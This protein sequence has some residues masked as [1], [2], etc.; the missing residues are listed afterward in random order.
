ME[1]PPAPPEAAIIR[2]AREAANIRIA[3][4]AARAGVSVARWSQIEAGS[5]LRHG[6]ASPVTGRAG[7]IAR[8]AHVAGVSPERL[9][10]AGGRPDAAEI[11]REIIRQQDAAGG[12][13]VTVAPAR[14]AASDD[15][16]LQKWRQQV[17]REA[18]GAAGVLARLGPGELPEPDDIPGAAEVLLGL[19][20]ALIFDAEHE[21]SAWDSGALPLEKKINV[22]ALT[23]RFAARA[24][25]E[26]GRRTGLGH[27]AATGAVPA[28]F[29]VAGKVLRASS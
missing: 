18:Y 8:M 3:D 24:D 2:L 11:L 26:Q 13:A 23:R 19:P 17:L 7:T 29:P 25:E 22:I 10:D 9:A 20:G 5:E 14:P 15:P 16:D 6:E 28:Q 12:A 1:R 4:A 27:S 21:V